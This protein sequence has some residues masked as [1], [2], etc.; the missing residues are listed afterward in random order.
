MCVAGKRMLYYDLGLF[1]CVCVKVWLNPYALIIEF[2][3]FAC[4]C[5]REFSA[6]HVQVT[7][8]VH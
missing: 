5:E 6:H 1:P 8:Q 3:F 4:V 7:L 2:G